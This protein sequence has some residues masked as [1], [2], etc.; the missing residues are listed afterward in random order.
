[1]E[2]K[3]YKIVNDQF[4][5]KEV[6]SIGKGALPKELRGTFTSFREVKKAIDGVKE[7]KGVD[8]GEAGSPSRG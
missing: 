7:K 2:Y 3:G 4:G 6:H 5:N 1:M 8:N